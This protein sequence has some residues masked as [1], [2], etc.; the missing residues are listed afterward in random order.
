MLSNALDYI[1][2]PSPIGEVVSYILVGY[3]DKW[4]RYNRFPSP[5][6]EVVSYIKVKY[7]QKGKQKSFR[8]LSGK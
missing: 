2:F 7:R 8:P 3:Y 5:I 6:G 1:V 4:Y